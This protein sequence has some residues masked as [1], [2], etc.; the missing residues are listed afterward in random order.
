MLK[1]TQIILSIP[2]VMILIEVQ[3]LKAF[4]DESSLFLFH[5]NICLLSKNTD[6]FEHLI[7]SKRCDF[8]IVAVS[9]SKIIK[10]KLP[11]NDLSLPNYTYEFYP[12][13]ASAGSTLIYV[14]NHLSSKH[15]NDITI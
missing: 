8:E 11:I 1:R 7:K 6:R 2:T 13:E 9:K 3:T 10:N 5:L 14:I 4:A 12:T 15:R